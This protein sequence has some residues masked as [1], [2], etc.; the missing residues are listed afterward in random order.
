ML[1]NG[2]TMF[3]TKQKML[4]NFDIVNFYPSITEQYLINAI[5][6]AKNKYTTIEN[7]DLKLI[8]HTCKAISTFNKKTLIKKENSN[9]FKVPMGSFFSAELCYIIG[10][11]ALSKLE[12]VYD[13]KEIGLYRDD[14]LAIIQP[15]NSQ[16]IE[17]KKKKKQ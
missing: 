10:L 13:P 16:V 14:G 17:N 3:K 1:S 4:Y 9:F 7:R 5:N 8:K 11:Y 15:K 2:F 12:Y 6:F